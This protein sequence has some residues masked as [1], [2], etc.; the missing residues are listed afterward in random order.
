M[1]I[2]PGPTSLEI[3]HLGPPKTDGPLPTVFYFALSGKDSLTL[4]PFN[5]FVQFLADAPIRCFSF[6]LPGHG[7]GLKNEE[8]INY[9]AAE[10]EKG[11]D[12]LH[13][14]LEAAYANICYLVEEQWIDPA[15][16]AVSGLS[17][18]GFFGSHLAL[19]DARIQ[20]IIAFAPIT[21]LSFLI[22]NGKPYD[23]T[24]SIDAFTE[25]TLR[26]Y[27]G[28]R[29]QRVSTDACFH[30]I[31]NVADRAFEKGIRSP[32]AELI[33]SASVGHMGHG[34]APATFLNGANWLKELFT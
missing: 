6:S 13:P 31:R 25:K 16:M 14:F 12:P 15:K 32:K 34:T 7:P 27:I 29:D 26:F 17:R 24:E 33:I 4:D 8:A 10:F 23:L 5:Q 21:N 20:T 2:I 11:I 9:V 19:K 28:N 30:F 18:G 22:P 3:Y 1:Q